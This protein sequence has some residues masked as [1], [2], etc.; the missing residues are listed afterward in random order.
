M[1]GSVSEP[2]YWQTKKKI[3][4]KIL[5]GLSGTSFAV[6]VHIFVILYC[7]SRVSFPFVAS[8][9]ETSEVGLP[10]VNSNVFAEA[11]NVF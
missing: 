11:I 8:L 5:T 1:E 4:S 2:C 3:K 10:E 9:M 7:M 6:P